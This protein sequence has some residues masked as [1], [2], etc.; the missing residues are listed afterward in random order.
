MLTK[1]PTNS[2]ILNVDDQEF[3]N[4]REFEYFGFTLTEI[5][6]ERAN[7]TLID[8]R[9][10]YN[11]LMEVKTY[12]SKRKDE[13]MFR[14]LERRILGRICGSIK[15]N[16]IWRAMY[17]RE[18]YKLYNEPDTMKVIKVR[19]LKWLGHLFRMQKQNPCRKLTLHKPE[20]TRRV[21][22]PAV[23]WLDSVEADL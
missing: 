9:K 2:G 18:F 7:F 13:N 22:R 11:V 20:G 14:N 12:P 16:V 6:R 23:R 5:F 8:A 19:R 4:V 17:N 21:G 3:Q 15:E 10:A 1:M